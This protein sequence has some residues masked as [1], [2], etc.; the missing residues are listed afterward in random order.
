MSIDQV[1]IA[2]DDDALRASLGELLSRLGFQ[3]LEAADGP[4][5]LALVR[6]LVRQNEMISSILDYH[7]PGMTALDILRSLRQERPHGS[8]P[9]ILMSA[10]AS[11]FEQRQALRHGAFRFLPKPF[12]VDNLLAC[13]GEMLEEFHPGP[14]GQ[15]MIARLR[16]GMRPETPDASGLPAPLDMLFPF[17]R[18]DPDEGGRPC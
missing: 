17:R 18:P 14:S 8:F 15:R 7:M 5:A 12:G 4:S 13:V 1:L 2:D 10:E 6:Q 11:A 3:V 9:C 16:S